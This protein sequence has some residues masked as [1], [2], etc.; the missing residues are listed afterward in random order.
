MIRFY[1]YKGCGTC[2]KARKWLES[3]AID[4][5]E[6]AIREHPPTLSELQHAL[7]ITGRLKSLFNTSGMDYRQMNMKDKLPSLAD[8]DALLLLSKNGNLVKRPFVIDDEICLTGFKP[9]EW[10][11]QLSPS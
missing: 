3:K 6:I 11:E 1:A 9:E 5:K 4:F 10:Q 8:S 7:K 2:R